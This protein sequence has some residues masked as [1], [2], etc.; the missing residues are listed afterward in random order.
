MGGV[1]VND[2]EIVHHREMQ[3]DSTC[4]KFYVALGLVWCS[5]VNSNLKRERR[6]VGIL[7]GGQD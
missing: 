1:N 5:G 4:G 6:G 2:A 3:R 7:V